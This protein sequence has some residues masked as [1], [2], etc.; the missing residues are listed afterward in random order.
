MAY[1]KLQNWFKLKKAQAYTSLVLSDFGSIGKGTLIYPPFHSNNASEVYL[2]ANC[3]V[4]AGGWIDTIREYYDA[5]HEGRIDIGD[6]T[7]F[8]HRVHI[9]ACRHMIIGKDVLVADNVYISDL[10]HGFEDIDVPMLKTPLVSPGPVVI[11]DQV[12]LGERACVLPNVRIGKHSV[13]GAN[14][15]VT[16]DIP[17]YS[18][19]AG[20]PAKVI[21]RYNPATGQWE[22]V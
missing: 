6:G 7:Y 1:L 16:K 20:V 10:F 22:K 4:H 12:W 8:G 21:K 11:E 2:G 15:V 18:V 13:V 9:C 14:A 17:P 19:A 5:R 3:Q